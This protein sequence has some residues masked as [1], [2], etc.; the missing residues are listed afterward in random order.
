MFFFRLMHWLLV[1]SAAAL[2]VTGLSL[3]AAARPD[4]SLFSGVVPRWLMSGYMNWWHTVAALVFAPAVVAA[5]WVCWR[6]QL[7]ARPTHLILLGGGLLTI[8]TGWL[9]MNPWGS[10][11]VYGLS[12]FIHAAVGLLLIPLGF[13]WHGVTGLTRYRRLLWPAFRPWGN[14]R[15]GYL[16]AFVVLAVATTCLTLNG[17]PVHFPWRNLVARPLPGGT[18]TADMAALPWEI[19]PPLVI[20]AANGMGFDA[21]QTHVTLRALHDDKELFLLAQW[22]DPEANYRYMPWQKTS[23]GW[24]HLVTNPDDESV[25]YEDKFS[26]AFP[27]V[28]DWEF[29]RFGCAASCH[30]GGGRP[31]GFKGSD[32]IV[33]SWHWK[34]TRTDPVGQVDDKYWHRIDFKAK[35]GGR[36]GDPKE[37]GGYDKNSA[38]DGLRPAF[39]PDEMAA[40][41]HG[42]IPREHAVPYSEQEAATLPDETIIPGIV[43]GPFVGD[44]GDVLCKSQHREGRWNLWIRRK[45]DTGSQYDVRFVPGGSH[46]FGCAAFDRTSKRHAYGLMPY[47]L[48]LEP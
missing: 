15:W 38:K 6:G 21:G 33:D 23:D 34:S 3:H 18:D 12:R 11:E 44:R 25:Y 36:Y 1:V 24:R 30:V 20:A 42:I 26:L 28:H 46:P 22:D 27:T 43:A 47:R 48:V 45:L 32:S 35:D 39:L 17:L 10:F 41:Y 16:F 7:F 31:Y 29:D 19:A 13:L 5:I 40:C 37:G 8:I 14:V 4:W 9:L 2:I